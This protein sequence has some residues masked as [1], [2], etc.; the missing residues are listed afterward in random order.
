MAGTIRTLLQ[1]SHY[2][3]ANART[4]GDL[5]M[6]AAFVCVEWVRV[7]WICAMRRR[8]VRVTSPSG[9]DCV[10]DVHGIANC[11]AYELRMQC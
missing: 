10:D 11:R 8:H 1:L 2:D 6:C 9:A 4:D 7:G 3:S 5:G